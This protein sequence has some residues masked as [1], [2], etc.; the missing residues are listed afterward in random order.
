MT[1]TPHTASS[2]PPPSWPV[3]GAELPSS[4]APATPLREW[5]IPIAGAPGDD[6]RIVMQQDGFDIHVPD[7]RLN[8]DESFSIASTILIARALYHVLP[9]RGRHALHDSA[10]RPGDLDLPAGPRPQHR[11][12]P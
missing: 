4:T 2:D 10:A 5:T 8:S 6:A 3:A 7:C 12:E 1:S 11:R 9:S